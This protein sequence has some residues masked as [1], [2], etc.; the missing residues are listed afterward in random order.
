MEDVSMDILKTWFPAWIDENGKSVVCIR[1]LSPQELRT[2]GIVADGMAE[3]MIAAALLSKETGEQVYSIAEAH[4]L[5]GLSDDC[6][7]NLGCQILDFS[8]PDAQQVL[9]D[10]GYLPTG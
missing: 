9:I 5:S 4:M 3:R 6:K 10:L 1:A 8:G 2:L 7:I